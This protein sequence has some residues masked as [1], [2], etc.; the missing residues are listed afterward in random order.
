MLECGTH[1]EKQLYN[2]YATV[3]R[4]CVSA[5]LTKEEEAMAYKILEHILGCVLVLCSPI[6]VD[7]FARLLDVESLVVSRT[8]SSMHS[9]M[10][11]SLNPKLPFR[12]HHTSFGDSLQKQQSVQPKQDSH[13]RRCIAW[14]SALALYTHYGFPEARYPSGLA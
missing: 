12:L 11:I 7:A 1:P 14:H 6:S 10:D 13:T 3:S 5:N 8:L 9:I 4:T 2:I